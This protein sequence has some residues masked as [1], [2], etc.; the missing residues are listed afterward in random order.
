[1]N[2]HLTTA[3]TAGAVPHSSAATITVTSVNSVRVHAAPQSSS[4][5]SNNNKTLMTMGSNATPSPNVNIGSK[6]ARVSS[7]D[8]ELSRKASVS[9]DIIPSGSIVPK[10]EISL[11]SDLKNMM[12]AFGDTCSPLEESIRTMESILL[13]ELQG[14][15]FVCDSIAAISGSKSLN[16]QEPFY[17]LR[18]EKSRLIRLLKYFVTKDHQQKLVRLNQISQSAVTPTK[19]YIEDI[20]IILDRLDESGEF[21]RLLEF[22]YI[23]EPTKIER[24]LRADKVNQ[25]ISC[26][27]YF[28]YSKAR[29]VSFARKIGNLQDWVAANTHSENKMTSSY[30]E[31]LSF[32]AY[33]IVSQMVD[34]SFIVRRERVPTTNYVARLSDSRV[35]N[36]ETCMSAPAFQKRKD[37]QCNS[38]SE[39]LVQASE[40]EAKR[41]KKVTT[42]NKE[43]QMAK[44]MFALTPN[45]IG[46]AYCRFQRC[47]LPAMSYKVRA[48]K[49][50]QFNHQY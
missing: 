24:A 3:V 11:D 8:K 16:L 46:E 37:D 45:E 25:K 30:M 41:L 50:R 39:I 17:A 26:P 7:K 14:F 19:S 22:E 5:L 32:L 23:L 28:T 21:S 44:S 38:V 12:H 15:V 29:S 6:R 9:S 49:L 1:M 35:T 40:L 33:E 31:V 34:L 27:K 20:R 36:P 18:N 10:K 42:N 2:T 13:Q 43:V 4:S 48:E 47:V